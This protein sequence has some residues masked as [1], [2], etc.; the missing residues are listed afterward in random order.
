MTKS[1]FISEVAAAID[2]PKA[3]VAYVL[4][5]FIEVIVGRMEAGERV[6]LPG[7]GVFEPYDVPTRDLFGG[8][9]RSEGKRSM[10]FRTSRRLVMEKYGVQ[11]DD[12][13]T[14]T[15]SQSKTCPKCGSAL[16]IEQLAN[17]HC[18]KCGTEP[19]EKKSPNNP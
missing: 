9:R 16:S 4:Y 15:A 1:E 12:E 13:K 17:R 19:W 8:T 11:Y 10:R 14:K 7:F 6:R 2:R 5:G 18:P 3:E